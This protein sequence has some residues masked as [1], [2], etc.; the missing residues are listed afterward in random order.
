[1]QH[2]FSKDFIY[3]PLEVSRRNVVVSTY[4]LVFN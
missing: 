2:Q 3:R 4:E 1:M